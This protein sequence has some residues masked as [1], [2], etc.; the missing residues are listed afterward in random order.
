LK[1]LRFGDNQSRSRFAIESDSASIIVEKRNLS[2]LS[3]IFANEAPPTFSSSNISALIFDAPN[4]T[5][6]AMLRASF[7]HMHSSSRRT[8]NFVPGLNHPRQ[9][10]SFRRLTVSFCEVGAV[11]LLT[12]YTNTALPGILEPGEVL[13]PAHTLCD[14][15]GLWQQSLAQKE[16][17]P[18]RQML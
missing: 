6:E 8:R 17:Q 10:L 9:K 1:K 15:S 5:M 4:R 14:P 13:K 18:G 3:Q 11:A 12:K 2:D 7:H 16:R